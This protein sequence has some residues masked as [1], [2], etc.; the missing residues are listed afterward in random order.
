[1]CYVVFTKP[2]N[3]LVVAAKMVRVISMFPILKCLS[4]NQKA[5]LVSVVDDVTERYFV[6]LHNCR[7]VTP[8]KEIQQLPE[9]EAD[10]AKLLLE[11]Q[12]ENKELRVQLAHLQQKVLTLQARSLV[13]NCSPTPSSVTSLLSPPSS[14]QPNEKGNPDPPS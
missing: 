1:M 2:T 14:S 7:H 3:F 13:E 8:M 11:L 5:I 9:S 4:L 10:Q 6:I 12:K